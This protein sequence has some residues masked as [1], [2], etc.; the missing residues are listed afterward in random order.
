MNTTEPSEL[1]LAERGKEVDIMDDITMEERGRR[2][3]DACRSEKSTDLY[4]IFQ[5]IAAQDFVRVNGPEHHVLDGACILTAYKN[6]G[7]D[8][9][10][11]A[12]L[13]ELMG[14][15]LRMPGAMCGQWGVCGA[16]S[17]AGAAL[18]IIEGT[19]PL[20]SDGSWGRNMEFT[21]DV[22]KALGEM[23]GPRCC[24]RGAFT[25]FSICVDFIEKNTGVKL[26]KSRAVCAF[27]DKNKQCHGVSC[28][29]H[30]DHK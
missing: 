12:A 11:D 22:L 25:A 6:A 26:G 21:A 14:R 16:V 17:S 1:W 5:H 7:G 19:G 18:S 20:S 3:I 23:D 29:Y 8:L 27:Y 13:T 24:K 30:P 9:D 15:G 2:I 28:T 4:I 10:L